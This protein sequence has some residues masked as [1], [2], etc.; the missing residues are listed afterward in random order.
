M[1][2]AQARASDGSL[3]EHD[4]PDQARSRG[5]GLGRLGYAPETV[6]IHTAQRPADRGPSVPLQVPSRLWCMVTV[7]YHFRL[8]L[9]SLAPMPCSGLL[10]VN[11]ALIGMG[12][13]PLGAPSGFR[14]L[15]DQK[16]AIRCQCGSGGLFMAPLFY[17]APFPPA[18]HSV[19][20][21]RAPTTNPSYSSNSYS[22][23]YCY[24]PRSNR[25]FLRQ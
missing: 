3:R 10:G 8:M 16:W 7:W 9:F 20:P 11:A 21:T 18:P 4:L 1:V 19:S 22:F 13:S 23:M 12:V 17:F 15:C 14:V 2:L 5:S 25:R 6:W 24:C